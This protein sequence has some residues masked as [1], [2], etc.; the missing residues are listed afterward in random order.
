MVSAAF[1]AVPFTDVGDTEWYHD[2]VGYVYDNGLM[3]GTSEADFSPKMTMS[4]AM[5]VTVLCKMADGTPSGAAN[6]FSD[7]PADKWYTPTVLWA[8]EN[9]VAAGTPEGR[10]LPDANVTRQDAACLI[11]SFLSK[12]G[13]EAPDRPI[14]Q[15]AF[16][17]M[18]AA[19]PYARTAI[20]TMRRAGLAAGDTN[21]NYNPKSFLTRAE[22]AVLFMNLHKIVSEAADDP[23][24]PTEPTEPTAPTEPTE[25]TD[26]TDPTDPT[27]AWITIGTGAQ[28]AEGW[29]PMIP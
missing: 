9:G 2:A 24:D 5:F 17:D 29:L 14:L 23:V 21:G 4:R 13:I 19:A 11:V 8:Y 27:E 1:A 22:A 16:S 12:M 25:P 7:V 18:S 26:P 28:D 3:V 6:P 15:R 10:F 20:E